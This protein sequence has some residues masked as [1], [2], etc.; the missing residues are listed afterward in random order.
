MTA[1]FYEVHKRHKRR[2]FE[3]MSSKENFPRESH[4]KILK[5]NPGV[6]RVAS[7]RLSEMRN[8]NN[9]PCFSFHRLRTRRQYVI[10]FQYLLDVP[11]D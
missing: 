3:H 9:F 8:K 1:F 2:L 10:D 6:M 4:E 7:C 11:P 5:I